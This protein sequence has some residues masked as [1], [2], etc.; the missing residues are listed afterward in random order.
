MRL[1]HFHRS[2][3][4][5]SVHRCLPGSRTVT[6]TR[7]D[8]LSLPASNRRRRGGLDE[9]AVSHGVSDRAEGP[10]RGR[11]RARWQRTR[12]RYR[13]ARIH[14]LIDC[15]AV[16]RKPILHRGRDRPPALVRG[17]SAVGARPESG[18]LTV[19]EWLLRE[20]EVAQGG[21]VDGQDRLVRPTDVLR[22]FCDRCTLAECSVSL[23]YAV[24]T[25]TLGRSFWS[26]P[27]ASRLPHHRRRC[28]PVPVR[29]NSTTGQPR[30]FITG[31]PV[32]ESLPMPPPTPSQRVSG[33]PSR[34]CRRPHDRVA[35]PSR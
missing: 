8:P 10:R 14:Y 13:Q 20:P 19:T 30:P 9:R 7:R 12:V 11:A 25:P 35:T 15:P 21:P 2:P 18:S 6:G 3:P 22:P 1:S 23:G 33:T 31:A 28:D 17:R 29:T 4:G 32:V 26:G 34:R 27:E 16:G 24:R 5:Q